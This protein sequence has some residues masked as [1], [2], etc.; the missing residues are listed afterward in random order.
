[1][2]VDTYVG[3]HGTKNHCICVAGKFLYDKYVW[4]NIHQTISIFYVEDCTHTIVIQKQRLQN[5][6]GCINVKRTKLLR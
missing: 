6:V 5:L 1:M 4:Q 3:I 2:L